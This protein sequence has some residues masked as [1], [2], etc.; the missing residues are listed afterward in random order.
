MWLTEIAHIRDNE[1]FVDEQRVGPYRFW[2]HEH[3]FEQQLDGVKMI[4]HVTYA[5]PFGFIGEV[6]HSLWVKKRLNSIFDYRFQKV[7]ELFA[8]SK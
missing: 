3:R 5:L 1:Y 8:R 2:Y 7:E 4:D 6:V